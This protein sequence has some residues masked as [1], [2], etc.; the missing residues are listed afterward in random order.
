MD[1][2]PSDATPEFDDWEAPDALFGDRPIRER[3][4]DV[5]LGLREPTRVA[6]VAERADCDPETAREY[7]RWF[8]DAGIVDE[9][10]GRP[11]RYEVNRSY[12]RWRRVE[13]IRREHT[14][15][16]IAA[17]LSELVADLAA[18]RERFD[19][20]NPEAVSLLDAADGEAVE[21]TWRALSDW[22]TARERADLLD[23]A[24][25]RDGGVSDTPHSVD[26]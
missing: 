8:A 21:E 23:A 3:L 19:A 16:E 18:Y 10:S 22:K 13:A 26:V 20:P 2:D 24:R 1:A 5:A 11:V 7:L 9:Q 17:E 4:L 15:E 6:T 25:R 14:T 12:L